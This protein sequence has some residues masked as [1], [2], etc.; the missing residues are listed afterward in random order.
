MNVYSGSAIPA[1]RCHV[2][3]QSLMHV[4][5]IKLD[6]QVSIYRL[7]TIKKLQELLTKVTQKPQ[8]YKGST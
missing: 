7:E 6:G 1:F 5:A 8:V 3:I 4:S 2:S